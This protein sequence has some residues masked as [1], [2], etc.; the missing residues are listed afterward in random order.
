MFE[1]VDAYAGDP[2]LTLVETFHK[3]TREQKVNLGIGLYYDEQGRIPLLPSVQQAEA[4]RAAAPAPRPY[5]PMDGAANYRT[6]VPHLLFG[7]GPEGGSAG[8][9]P[10]PQT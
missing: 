1:H 8:Q 6:A 9:P 3:D 2:I 7:A 5:Q 10:P 4:Q